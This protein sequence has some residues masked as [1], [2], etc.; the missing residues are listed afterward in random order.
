MK[1]KKDAGGRRAKKIVLRVFLVVAILLLVAIATG[2]GA[3]AYVAITLDSD[4][5][6]AV[7]EAMRGSR[8]TRIW[9]PQRGG[10]GEIDAEH[11]S[12]VE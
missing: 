9:A 10:G 7:M 1:R 5:D 2:V 11:Y 8:T 6:M 12:P 4:E 3:V